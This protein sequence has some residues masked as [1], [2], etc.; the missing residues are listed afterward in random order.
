MSLATLAARI[1]KSDRRRHA[2]RPAP[3]PLRRM[4][5]ALL[6]LASETRDILYRAIDVTPGDA[7]H[8][9]TGAAHCRRRR[10]HFFES[11][12]FRETPRY[13][14]VPWRHAALECLESR[15]LLTGN[16]VANNDSYVMAYYAGGSVSGPGVLA[17]DTDPNPGATLTA[18]LVTGPSHSTSFGLNSDGSFHY[19]TYN[20]FLGQDSFTYYVTDNFGYTSNTATV[21]LNVEYSVSATTDLT[22]QVAIDPLDTGVQILGSANGA[23]ATPQNLSLAYDSVAG[24]PDTVIEGFFQVNTMTAIPDT[25]TGTLTVNGVQQPA[26]YVNLQG[27]NGSNVDL[28]YQVDTS[29]L[30]TGRYPY[31]LTLS[32]PNMTAPATISG[33]VN[34]VNDAN[35]PVGKGWDIPGLY[36]VYPNNVQGVPAGVLLATGVDGQGWYFTQGSGNSF[37]SPHGPLAFDTLTSVTGGGWQLVD[38]FGNTFNFNSG[39]FETSRVARN[40]ETDTYNWSGNNLVS[41]VDPFSRTVNIGNAGGQLSSVADFAG[42]VWTIAH[43]GANLTS[44]TEPNPG[45]GAPVFQFGYTGNYLSSET[46]PNGNVYGFTLDAHHRLSGTSLPGGGSTSASSEQSMAYGGPTQQGAPNVTPSGNVVTT[47]TDANNNTTSLQTDVFGNPLVA[48]D[49][50]GNKTTWQRDANGLVTQLTE[51]P[52]VP[53]DAAPVTNYT[54][55]GMGNVT[56]AT[57]AHPSYGTYVFN[58]FG[59]WTG[60]TNSQ[61]DV[62]TRSFDT[63]GGLLQTED[64]LQNIVSYTLDAFEN[65]LTMTTPAP[66]NAVGT[67][68]TAYAYDPYE[69]RIKTTW[70]DNSTRLVGYDVD[71]RPTSTT[72]ENGHVSKTNYDVLGR[73]VSTVDALN[74]VVAQTLDKDGN[75]LTTTDQMGNVTQD[76]WNARNEL[77]KQILPDPDGSGPLTSPVWQWSYDADANR[78]TQTDPMNRVTSW[79]WDKLN[80]M[81]QETLPDPDGA[82]PLTSPVITIGYDALSRKT[83]EQDPLGTTTW[84]YANTDVSQVTSMTLPDPDG[85]GPLTSPVWTYSYDTLGRK[86]QTTDPMSHAQ[87]ASFDADGRT[88]SVLDNLGHGP[89]YAYGHGGELLTTTDSLSHTTSDQYDSRYRLIQTTA[90]DGGVTQITLDPAG[91]RLALVDPAGNKTSWTVDALNRPV[92]ETNSL[93]TTTTSYDASSDVTSITDADGRVR[94]FAYDNLHQLTAENWMSGNTIVASM[95]Y[96]Y[97]LAGQLTSASDPNSAYAF[98]YNNDGAVLTGDNTATPNAPH[99][100][101]TS[102]VDLMGDRTSLAATIA[103]T[104]DFLN[105]Y[106]YD[107]DQRLTMVQQQQQTGGNT[108]APKEIDYAYNASGQF[109]AMVYYNYIGTGPRTDVATGAFSYDTGARLTGLAYTSNGGANSIDAFGWAYNA[110]NLVT[111]FTSIDGTASYSY[112]WPTQ[113]PTTF[114]S[115]WAEAV[116]EKGR[117]QPVSSKN[118]GGDR[119]HRSMRPAENSLAQRV[120]EVVLL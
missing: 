41:I 73:V 98:G 12:L 16:P 29:A 92:T 48:T 107:A 4:L 20:T 97:D 23:P 13:S 58:T 90:A 67:V 32:S 8:R 50:Y 30:P 100:L 115:E 71:D 2:A 84:A 65:P 83:S 74:G 96:A 39:G 69:R 70:A 66:N 21:T 63:H 109:T 120:H 86:Y 113:P 15:V 40:T 93:G 60:F 77:I 52:P 43:S 61:N 9:R 10:G 31:S 80:R 49:P 54:L 59:E 24:Q 116:I 38:K 75:V 91:N 89:T 103:G 7:R 118:V 101:L 94:D 45:G 114:F 79:T 22:K 3:R 27:M 33:A 53:G 11:L 25:P 36:H 44:I 64:P 18:H 55:D 5:N 117:A 34:V 76:F 17:N 81:T 88:T 78:L 72:D 110:G 112:L 119:R 108:V 26:T 47:V 68:T 102:T 35:S 57:G 95:A 6:S 99:V 106:S 14:I 46:D 1:S 87:T 42:N 37:T 105:S 104:A 56:S 82:G 62:W 28:S 111:S 19:A 51:P 85:S